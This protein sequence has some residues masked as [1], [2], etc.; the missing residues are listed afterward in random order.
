[1]DH[2][3]TSLFF[4]FWW[5]IFPLAWFIASA[6]QSWMRLRRH[7]AAMEVLKSYAAKGEEPPA[8]VLDAIRESNATTEV[9]ETGQKGSSRGTTTFLIL[10]MGG[11][12]AI[13]AYAGYAGM[14]GLGEEGYFIAMILGVVG[15]AFFG[16][17]IFGSKD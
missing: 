1:M 15:L 10:L 17:G 9:A 7:N 2:P 3:F 12:A 11:L 16:A 5:L 6:W 8:S 13:F 14:M 4:S